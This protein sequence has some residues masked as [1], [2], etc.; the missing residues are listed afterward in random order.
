M[1]YYI[2]ADLGTSSLKL[3]L[4]DEKK[5]IVKSIKREYPIFYPNPGW[6]EQNPTDWWNAFVYGVK[7]LVS[8]IEPKSVRGISVARSNARTCDFGRGRPGGTSC[9]FME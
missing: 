2:G 7:E 3:L 1:N 9:N 8:D 5:K 6:S 4:L